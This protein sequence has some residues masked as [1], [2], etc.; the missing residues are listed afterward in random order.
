T[1]GTSGLTASKMSSPNSV[2]VDGEGRLYVTDSGNKRVLRFD[3]AATKAAGAA[4]DGVLGKPDFVTNTPGTASQSN[5]GSLRYVYGDAAGRLYVIGEDHNRILVYLDAKNKANGANA[6]YVF[7]QPDFTTSAALNP[8]TASSFNTPRALYVDDLYA[9]IFVADYNNHRVLRFDIPRAGQKSLT[10]TSPNGGETWSVNSV[11]NITWTSNSVEK[12][13]IQY[14][15]NNGTA[16]TMVADSV[17]AASGSYAW[18]LPATASAQA[19]I[20]ISSVADAGLA[21]TSG[22]FTVDAP[23]STVTLLSP[24]GYQQ[25]EAGKNRSILFSSVA[26]TNVK[27]EYSTNNGAVWTTIATAPAAG[28]K[29]TW[30][31]PSAVSSQYRVKVSN[32][33]A[34][35]V[36]DS[37]DAPFTVTAAADSSQDYMIFD[38]SVPAGYLDPSYAAVVTAPSTIE[39]NGTKLPV[40]TKYGYRGN[41]SIK[42]N[43]YSAVT[44]NWI[45]AVA[46]PGWA[47]QDLNLRDTLVYMIFTEDSTKTNSLPFIFVEDLANN[48][49]TKLPLSNF[50]SSIPAKKWTRVAIPLKVF[51]QNA[52]PA[53]VTRIKTFFFAQ[54][55]ADTV[56]NTWYIGEMRTKGGKVLSG[57]S[58]RLIVVIGSSTAAGTG[59]TAYDSSWVGRFRSYVKTQDSTAAVVNLAIGGYTTYDAMPSSYVPPSGRPAPKVNNN[60]TAALKFKP[61]AVIISLPTNDIAYGYALSEQLANYDAIIA[62][63]P[64]NVP[65]F[66]STAQPRNLDANGRALLMQLRDSSAARYKNRALDFWTGLANSDGTVNALYNAGDGI[67]LNNAG[68]KVLFERVMAAG[69]WNSILNVRSIPAALPSAFAL[70]QNYPNPFNPATTIRFALPQHAEVQLKV[71]NMLGQE[72]ATLAN[73]PM[74]AGVHEVPF[75]ASELS[76]GVYVYRIQAGTFRLAKKMMLVK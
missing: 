27:L 64:K 67:H 63:V 19:R 33:D 44:G 40:V 18:T 14:S 7:G 10:L 59:A 62:Q 42:V 25:W 49:S 71:Y 29:Y 75:D 65:V 30:A 32:A 3:S 23:P 37:S 74:S 6:D 16:W 8:P 1:T 52:G 70:E 68:H 55:Q 54:N 4:A 69:V 56:Q 11:H 51:V 21:D 58:T 2:Y 41:N 43:W 48:K 39:N 50:V 66:V 22:T 46:N 28:G 35:S 31:V 60:I 47:G 45:A 73:G 17:P 61:H 34:L 20:L 12:V 24:N 13:R 5:L 36:S 76:S 26:V 72:V 38:E 15:S 57:D 53:D 9:R